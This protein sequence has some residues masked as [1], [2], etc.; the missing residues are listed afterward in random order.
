VV[1]EVLLGMAIGPQALDLVQA[2]GGVYYL[3]L[4]GFGFLLFLPGRR[5]RSSASAGPPSGS[6]CWPSVSAW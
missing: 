2:T 1:L 5:S 6:P 3:Y 4:L